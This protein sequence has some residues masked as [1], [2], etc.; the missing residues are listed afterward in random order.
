MERVKILAIAPYQGMAEIMNRQADR[1]KDIELTV[2]VGNA[3]TCR[4]ILHRRNEY[5]Y[6]AIVSRGGTAKV[7][8]AAATAPVVEIPVSVYDMLRCLK[9]LQGYNG[10]VAVIGFSN[11]TQCAVELSSVM[12]YQL[13]VCT[14][15]EQSDVKAELIKLRQAGIG[16][17]LCDQISRSQAEELGMNAVLLTSDEASIATAFDEAVNVCRRY[18][19]FHKRNEIMRTLLF[20]QEQQSVFFFANRY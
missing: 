2:E 15:T 4:Q 8:R 10:K 6:D 17:V 3:H 14:I 19:D 20:A 11:I 16:L 7:L 12:Q 13:D 1:R 5:E 9:S 18:G